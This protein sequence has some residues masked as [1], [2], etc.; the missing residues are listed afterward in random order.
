[1]KKVIF[2]TNIWIFLLISKKL[3]FIDDLL[4]NKKIT[5]I[6]SDELIDEI[7]IVASR[8][9]FKK[10]FSS[11]HVKSLINYI[12]SYGHKNY[13]ISKYD[14]CKDK[15]D[16]Y[17]L[18]LAIDSKSDYLITGDKE[19]LNTKHNFDFNIITYSDFINLSI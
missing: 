3:E 7:I 5:F 11:H 6:F 2:D 9:K 8:E 10:Y 19:L 1:M 18:N 4:K 14:L 15:E 17:L 12:I 16:N 13:I